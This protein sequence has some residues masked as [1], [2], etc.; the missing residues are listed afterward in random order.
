[1]EEPYGDLGIYFACFKCLL[2]ISINDY[3][4]NNIKWAEESNLNNKIAS[5]LQSSIFCIEQFDEMYCF[6]KHILWGI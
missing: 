1:M 5:F 4:N 3:I 2:I 6:Q